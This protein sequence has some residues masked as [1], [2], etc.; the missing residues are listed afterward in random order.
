MAILEQGWI[1]EQGTV[2]DIFLNPHSRTGKL[3]IK[4]H[5]EFQQ[6]Q[7]VGEGEGI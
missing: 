4:I 7:W 1:N 2:R 5:S 3:F 6:K